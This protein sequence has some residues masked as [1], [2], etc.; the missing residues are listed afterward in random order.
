MPILTNIGTGLVGGAGTV[1][2]YSCSD[3][4]MMFE[5][6]GGYP[7]FSA[8]GMNRCNPTASILCASMMADHIGYEIQGFNIRKALHK[9]IK[10][11]KYNT[12]DQGGY[13]STTDFTDAVIERL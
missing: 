11:G 10:T 2:S 6:A 4:I 8:A 12:R 5:T 7:Y 3:Q 13:C 1:A 9:T